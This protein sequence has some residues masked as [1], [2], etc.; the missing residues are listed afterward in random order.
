MRILAIGDIHYVS[1]SSY[2]GLPERKYELGPE[3]VERILRRKKKILM[4]LLYVVIL[5]ITGLFHVQK[6]IFLKLKKLLKKRKNHLFLSE[7]TMILNSVNFVNYP[8]I[9]HYL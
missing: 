3:F 8:E 1:D 6:M 5:L 2:I 7:E 4:L 9:Q